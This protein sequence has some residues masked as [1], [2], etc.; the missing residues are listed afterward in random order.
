MATYQEL[1]DIWNVDPEDPDAT[2]LREKIATATF[3][4][5]ET[6]YGEVDTTPNHV[7][8]LIWAKQALADAGSK[9]QELLSALLAQNANA[10]V[11]VILGANDSTVQ[12]AVDAAVDV[13]ADGA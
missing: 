9:R 12:N 3:I 13:F 1:Y 4:A 8:R 7:N 5:A 10:S 11:A 6:I 2:P